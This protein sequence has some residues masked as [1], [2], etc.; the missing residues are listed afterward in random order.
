MSSLPEGTAVTTGR[1]DVQF[2][3]TERGCINLKP[4]TAAERAMA[5]IELAAPQFREQLTED[6]KR[7]H[8]L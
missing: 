1:Q 4:L 3:V 8:I 5:L 2:V 7:L 6:A